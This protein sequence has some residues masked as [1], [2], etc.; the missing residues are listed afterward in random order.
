MSH[1]PRAL[2]AWGSADFP[3][4]LA[5]EI[6]SLGAG[7][8]PLSALSDTGY[9]LETGVAVSVIGARAVEGRIE[10][11]LRVYFQQIVAGC[12]CGFEAQPEPAM[13]ELLASIDRVSAAVRLVAVAPDGDAA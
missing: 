6:L 4:V 2:A 10:V 3:A 13:G 9:A 5:A 11:R 12:S 8:L 1:L 7:G